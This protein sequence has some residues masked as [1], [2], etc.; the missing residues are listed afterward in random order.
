MIDLN[1]KA[2]SAT[3]TIET[4]DITAVVD[5]N[6]LLDIFSCRDLFEEFESSGAGT[7]DGKLDE[8]RL[9][10]LARARES[11]VLAMYF[12]RISATTFSLHHEAL[13]LLERVSPPQP[14]D[15]FTTFTTLLIH[16]VKDYLLPRWRITMP[17]EP[18]VECSNAADAALLAFAKEHRVPLI[19]NEGYRPSGIVVEKLRKDA[20]DAGVP[21]FTPREFCARKINEV[22][23]MDS[24]FT[25][26]EELGY[27]YL[28]DHRR[29]FGP[30][31]VGTNL[32]TLFGYYRMVLTGKVEGRDAP[33]RISFA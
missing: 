8:P 1:A 26:F 28:E 11:M 21:V 4:S 31:N 32:D 29:R 14:S 9:V 17:T 15:F 3:V 5:T 25:R 6:V 2:P 20:I 19:T 10:Q 22:D 27:R 33:I 18:G 13:V 24:F 23:E 7:D 30:G 12:D 16:F